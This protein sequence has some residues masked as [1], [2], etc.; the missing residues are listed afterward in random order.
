[1]Q[2]TENYKLNKPEMS[3]PFTP[4][5]L[6]ENMDTVDA[7]MADLHQRVISLEGKRLLFGTYWGQSI[8]GGRIIDL[9]ERPLAAMV[10]Y[11]ATAAW[12]TA[13]IVKEGT[14][15]TDSKG[16]ELRD[17]GFWINGNLDLY[18]GQYYFMAAFGDWP[19]VQF[20]K[21]TT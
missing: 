15:F 11:F 3:D 21:P 8:N 14:V 6:S 5:P 18:N 1:M 17:N 2:Q 12:R 19:L 20:P 7:A 4:A 13:F 10:F 9:G 16:L